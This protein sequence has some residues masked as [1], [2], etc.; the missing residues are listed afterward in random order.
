MVL[1]AAA[2]VIVLAG[3]AVAVMVAIKP[4][5]YE[6]VATVNVSKILF[7]TSGVKPGV[8]SLK[9]WYVVVPAAPLDVGSR[10]IQVKVT[11]RVA[12]LYAPK[13]AGKN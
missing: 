13:Y 7:V 12:L 8:V 1:P 9:I 5:R 2:K 4:F 10:L 11:A 6:T 3:D